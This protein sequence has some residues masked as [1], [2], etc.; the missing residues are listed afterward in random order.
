MKRRI[1]ALLLA[2]A[3]AASGCAPEAGQVIGKD[4]APAHMSTTGSCVYV[5]STCHWTQVPMYEPDTYYLTLR[6]G[7]DEGDRSVPQYAWV[8]C[9]VGSR[10][11]ECAETTQ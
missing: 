10:Y 7:E 11:P 6:N 1:V 8:R 5:G 2:G 3:V 9:P 4:F